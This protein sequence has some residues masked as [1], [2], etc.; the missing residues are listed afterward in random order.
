MAIK[1]FINNLRIASRL[2]PRPTV[3]S[4]RG[5]LAAAASS[6]MLHAADLW[7]T[8]QAVEGFDLADFADLP[9]TERK[10]LAVEVAAFLRIAKQIPANKP[11]TRTMSGKARSH[12]E[13]VVRIVGRKLRQD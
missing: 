13:A 10:E 5:S 2:L 9:T 1:D 4:G 7:L 8:P 6:T 11:A 3:S 12:L